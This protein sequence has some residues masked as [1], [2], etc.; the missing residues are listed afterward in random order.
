MTMRTE[1]RST[2]GTRPSRP[3]ARAVRDAPASVA[4]SAATKPAPPAHNSPRRDSDASAGLHGQ[5]LNN[6]LRTLR[7]V[8]IGRWGRRTITANLGAPPHIQLTFLSPPADF[9]VCRARL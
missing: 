4:I 5:V 2:S 9:D 6:M 7:P 8:A 1:R 3:W